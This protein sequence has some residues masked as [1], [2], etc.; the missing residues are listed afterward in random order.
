GAAR[1]DCGRP[2]GPALPL[3]HRIVGDAVEPDLSVAPRLVR[4]P[5]HAVIE[6][7]G[8][9]G[10]P[11]VEVAGRATG[12]ARVDADADVAVGHPLLGIDHFPV[13]VLVRRA[14]GHVRMLLD[15]AAP[16]VG[17]EILEVQPP[18]LPPYRT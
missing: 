9:A 7:L 18:A 8:L 1:R 17:V 14:C 12:T 16:L 5:L 2:A 4:R 15:H 3:I 6:V 13:L 11:E 10:R